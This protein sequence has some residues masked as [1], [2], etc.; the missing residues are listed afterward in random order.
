MGLVTGSRLGPYEILAPIGKSGMGKC[1]AHD[2]PLRRY[3][4]IKAS[5]RFGL[6][7]RFT[8]RAS[9]TPGGPRA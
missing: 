4:T 8:R 3:V 9:P 1:I 6:T 7:E 5:K 2:E